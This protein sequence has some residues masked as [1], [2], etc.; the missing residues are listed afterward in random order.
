MM[1]ESFDI[2]VISRM[3]IIIQYANENEACEMQG[4]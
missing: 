4:V 2:F 1:E 3:K